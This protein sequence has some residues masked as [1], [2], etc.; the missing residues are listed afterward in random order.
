MN[1]HKKRTSLTASRIAVA[2]SGML[3]FSCTNEDILD[4][5]NVGK[6]SD[7]ICF[8]ITPD[9]TAQARGPVAAEENG[10][11]SGRFVLRSDDSTDTLCVRAIVSDGI[12]TSSDKQKITRGTPITT[13]N[14]NSFHVLAYWKN[15][16]NLVNQFYMNED[17]T[18]TGD[19][20]SSD[21]IYY[22]LGE[23]NTLQFY[24]WSP[25][26]TDGLTVPTTPTSTTL[27]YTVPDDAA[28]QQDIVVATT[29]ELAG[30]YNQVVPLA[31]DHI[32]TAVRFVTGAQMQPGTIKSVSLEGVKYSGS[33]D[34]ATEQ[35]SLT[36]DSKSFTQTLEKGM[37]GGETEGSE[38]TKTE[39]TF[40]MLPQTLPD[41]AKVKV[42]FHS[43]ATNQDRE[44]KAPIANTEWPIGKTV[45]YKLSITPEYELDF[46]SEPT[47]QD[48]HYVIYP[49]TIKAKDVPAGSWTLTSSS[50][51]V[52]LRTDLTTLNKRGFW[53]EEDKG[54]QSITSTA[55]GDAITVYAFLTENASEE[56]REA[57]L[58]LR[59]TSLP[60]AEPSTFTISQLCPS[61]NGNIGC[62]RFEDKD[63]PWGFLWPQGMTVTYTM[64]SSGFFNWLKN[65][66]LNAYLEWFTDYGQFITKKTNFG[67]IESV[68]INYDAV[69]QVAVAKDEDNG[70]KN[71][72]ELY[73]F[74]GINDVSTLEDILKNWG[75]KTEDELPLNPAEFAARS[76]SMRNKY[77]KTVEQQG[78][79]TIEI[80]I[81]PQNE[82]T[83]YLPSKNEAPQMKDETYPLSGN[84]WT[85]TN[86]LGEH[87]NENAFKYSAGG[88]TTLG[89]RD[90][91]LHVRAVRKKP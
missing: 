46:T 85:S 17:V 88:S 18:K 83:W 5:V 87:D 60:N 48:A 76:A 68:T 79:E 40:M 71:T 11:T 47:L 90:V 29:K 23:S 84:Y 53:I 56:T 38:I 67:S 13:E 61:W 58:T 89:R 39:G 37:T 25:T 7:Q 55:T 35:W 10:Y 57:T 65:L 32:C 31:F 81:L 64:E 28:A 21:R 49:I 62:E 8:G 66:V 59:P 74:N 4:T 45:T 15:S 6:T 19:V 78:I 44:L 34:M 27:S 22:W 30:N 75:G 77:H 52:T 72:L 26:E 73:N 50:P 69:P 51:E 33:Y 36:D 80:P 3:L 86:S 1:G 91:N 9:E 24:A 54:T 2:L 63:D 43:I 82:I 12:Y 70:L 14:F 16:E 20:W 41:S 42:V